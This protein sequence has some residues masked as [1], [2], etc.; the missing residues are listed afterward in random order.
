MPGGLT[1]QLLLLLREEYLPAGHIEQFCGEPNA[2]NPGG[3]VWQR[4]DDPDPDWE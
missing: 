1:E 3:H 2:K 4:R